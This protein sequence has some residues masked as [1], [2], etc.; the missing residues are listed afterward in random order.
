LGRQQKPPELKVSSAAV[1][2]SFTFEQALCEAGLI[3]RHMMTGANVPMYKTSY[4][5]LPAGGEHI[6]SPIRPDSQADTR[7]IVFRGEMVV[8]M[9][10]YKKADVE[11]VRAITRP[12][13]KT[14]GEP[15]AWVSRNPATSLYTELNM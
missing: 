4:P 12:Y 8:S 15:V 2:C 7:I 11:K 14:H 3:P 13:V 6:R 9:R 5:L 10:P 1:G